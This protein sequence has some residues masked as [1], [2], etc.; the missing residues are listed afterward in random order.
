MFLQ[1]PEA[2][3]DDAPI[4]AKVLAVDVPELGQAPNLIQAYSCHTNNPRW[5]RHQEP[6][7]GARMR[8]L[9]AWSPGT[10]LKHGVNVCVKHAWNI[11]LNREIMCS[12]CNP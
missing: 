10:G 1:L 7:H 12:Q 3:Q 5:L 11:W 2:Q 8:T 9:L 4:S 6:K